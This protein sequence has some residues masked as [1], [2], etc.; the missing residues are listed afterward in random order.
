MAD[1]SSSVTTPTVSSTQV[2][3][4]TEDYHKVWC[5]CSQP[6]YVTVIM[7]E[8]SECSVTCFIVTV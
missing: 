1:S 5:S 6:S 7:C 2:N 3:K 8:E 4:E